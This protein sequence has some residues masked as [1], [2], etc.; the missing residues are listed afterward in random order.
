M[1]TLKWGDTSPPSKENKKA[2]K[3]DCVICFEKASDDI[4]ECVWCDGR[5]HAKCVKISEEQSAVLDNKIITNI[6]FFC[7][8]CLQTLPT[9]LK[10]Y[11]DLSPI[12][13]HEL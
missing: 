12:W 10:Y 7:N 9:A 4:L 3:E 6:M 13:I 1:S 8:L 2:K 5:M 11:D